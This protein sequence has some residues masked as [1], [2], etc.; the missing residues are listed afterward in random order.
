VI[1]HES[2]VGGGDGDPCL[3][4]LVVSPSPEKAALR[5]DPPPET[6]DAARLP[7]ALGSAER[8]AL[9]LPARDDVRCG[10]VARFATMSADGTGLPLREP[11]AEPGR[12]ARADDFLEI[13]GALGRPVTAGVA[14]LDSAADAFSSF[15]SSGSTSEASDSS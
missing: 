15:D 12:E 3:A 8:G 14:V 1:S 6:G 9:G 10:D 13:C 4:R 5:F 7:P 11:A 2:S